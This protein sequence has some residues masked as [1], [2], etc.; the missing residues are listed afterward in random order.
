MDRLER[1]DRAHAC[2]ILFGPL[3]LLLA[4]WFLLFVVYKTIEAIEALVR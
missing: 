1:S 2:R 4:A 3:Y